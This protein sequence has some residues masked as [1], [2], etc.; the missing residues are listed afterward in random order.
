MN[1]D[2][3]LILTNPRIFT[4]LWLAAVGFFLLCNVEILYPLC[5]RNYISSYCWKRNEIFFEIDDFN[6]IRFS[7]RVKL[8]EV[9][10]GQLMWSGLRRARPASII[11]RTISIDEI[12]LLSNEIVCIELFVVMSSLMFWI[13][14]SPR[15]LLST[16]KRLRDIS[17][18]SDSKSVD[19]LSPSSNPSDP[20][21]T[22][23]LRDSMIVTFLQ[24]CWHAFGSLSILK[25]L[26]RKSVVRFER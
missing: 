4:F 25:Q 2:D 20:L 22:R 13:P 8:N 23:F 26:E 7:I 17:C 16:T 14:S 15:L 11:S 6:S 10:W 5:I 12:W 1:C 21:T 19:D 9:M 18:L 3:A 24:N